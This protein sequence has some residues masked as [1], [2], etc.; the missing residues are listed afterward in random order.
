[1]HPITRLSAAEYTAR[2]PDLADLLLDAV[3][4][5]HSLGFVEPFERGAALDWWRARTPAVADGSLLVWACPG[6]R[7]VDGTVGLA[8]ESKPNG[9]HRAEVVKL[10]VH[11]DARGRGLGRALLATAE[12][13]A[14]ELGAGLLLLDTETGSV[15]ES[16]YTTAGWTR[17]G[18][19]PDYA[20]D[21][22]GALRDCS[23]FYKRLR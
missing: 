3:A 7:G 23:F 6:P 21:P 20:S 13:A 12:R 18:V 11:R 14:A 17:Y 9:R 22:S 19:V 10:M 5:G 1:M 16:L 2:V 4:G 15:A 8:L